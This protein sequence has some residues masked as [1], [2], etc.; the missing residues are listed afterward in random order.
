MKYNFGS[1]NYSG[2]HPRFMEAI[3]EAN[4][5]CAPAYCE[6]HYSHMAVAEFKKAFGENID[7]FFVFNGTGANCA[8]IRLMSQNFNSVICSEV[9]HIYIDESSAPETMG[10]TRLVPLKSTNGKIS[11]AQVE[12]CF[13]SSTGTQHH[14]QPKLVSIT[15]PTE[16]GTLYTK[17][18]IRDIA[19]VAHKYGG[20][21]QVDGAR[22]ANAAAAMG[23]SYKEMTI[24]LGVDIMSFGGTKN[25]MMMGEAVVISKDRFC[26][27]SNFPYVRKSLGQLYSKMRFVSAQFNAYLKD[28]FGISLASHANDMAAYLSEQIKAHV[29]EIEVAFGVDTNAVFVVM[30]P[31]VVEQMHKKYA[32][33]V[34]RED[35]NLVR[36]MCPFS[37]DKQIIDEFVADLKVALSQ[38]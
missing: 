3:A 36:L 23:C 38:V 10:G 8:S 34:W 32:F 12:E 5:G 4:N 24:D 18:E 29:P 37:T 13:A 30:S 27:S 19:A 35:L 17:D 16:L 21:L 14:T 1:D 20:Y 6:D 31:E 28:D 9:A 15:Q 33:Y 7:V 25:G 11:A 26:H 22:L 2:V